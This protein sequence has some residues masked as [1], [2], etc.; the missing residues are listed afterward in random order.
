MQKV[1]MISWNVNGI[2]AVFNKG[3]ADFIYKE[4]ADIYCFQETKA[5]PEQIPMEFKKI[6][7]YYPYFSSP[8]RKGYSGVAVY[9]KTK[10]QK[11]SY[12]LGIS[13][14]DEEG[15]VIVLDLEGFVLLNVYFPNG[16][17]SQAR[18]D[19]KMDFYDHFLKIINEL[20]DEGK[21]VIFCGDL[22]TAH[23][24]IDLARP[25]ANKN[26][27]GFLPQERAWIDKVVKSG[28]LDTFRLFNKEGGHYSWWDYK[29]RARERNVGWRLDY[30]FT[31]EELK[32]NLQ[33]SYILNSVMGSDHCPVVLEL[34]I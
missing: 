18:L 16:G 4:E 11:V 30:F 29:T 19:Y 17:A 32:N 14:F 13:R 26:N 25:K 31:A 3:L 8:I 22:N 28:Y 33:D 1:K 12:S 7:G 24:E 9:I 20:R 34:E 27:T 15:R 5:K 6:G 2:R 23:K 21:K 10:P